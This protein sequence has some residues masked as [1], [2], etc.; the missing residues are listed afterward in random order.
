MSKSCP[1]SIHRIDAH[2]VRF[3]AFEVLI[4]GLFLLMTEHLF[5][6]FLLLFDFLIRTLKINKL[7]PF[8]NIARFIIHRLDMQPKFCDE[9]PKRFSLYLGLAIVGFLTFFL[10][11]GYTEIATILVI[12]LLTCA[13]L[14]AAFDYCVGC[15]VYYYLQYFVQMNK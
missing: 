15:K 12:A 3:V 14:E 11:F 8:A 4:I 9:A 6:S 1:I 10:I 13:F 2:F 7:S 5:F